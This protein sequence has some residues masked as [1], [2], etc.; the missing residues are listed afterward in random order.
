MK[1]KRINLRSLRNEEWFNFFTEFKRFVEEI[2]ARVLNIEKLFG[3]FLFLYAI[4]DEIIEKILKSKITPQISTLDKKRDNTFKG[5]VQTIR[6]SKHHFDNAKSAA[7]RSLETLL[8]HYGNLAEKPYNEE[9]SGI[10]NF[11]QEFR[12]NYKEELSILDL[13]A[14]LD[15]LERDNN[16]FEEAILERNKEIS[17]KSEVR[18][19]DV[20][21]DIDACYK[22]IIQRIE[23][24]MLVEEEETNKYEPFVRML[25]TNIKRYLDAVAQRKGRANADNDNSYDEND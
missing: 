4:A 12:S 21:R 18:L 10:H 13:S 15:E 25:N 2:S 8:K 14:W 1:F 11:I 17:G 20:R 9:T 5:L 22:E 19:L 16:I 24:L 23:A 6:A 7:S 3:V